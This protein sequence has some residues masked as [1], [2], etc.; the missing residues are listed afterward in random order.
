[1]RE[2]VRKNESESCGRDRQREI[3]H[4]EKEKKIILRCREGDRGDTE[5]DRE[6]KKDT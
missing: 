6:R 4:R 5:K 1:M 3:S 2:I